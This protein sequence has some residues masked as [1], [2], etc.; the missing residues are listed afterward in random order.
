MYR[1]TE[2]VTMIEIRGRYNIAKV[3]ID[4]FDEISASQ[5]IDL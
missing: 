4:E 1:D 3:F 5:I 2:G